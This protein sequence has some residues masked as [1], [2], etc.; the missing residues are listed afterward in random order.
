MTP[1]VYIA[2]GNCNIGNVLSPYDVSIMKVVRLIS[3]RNRRS[4]SSY[5]D[6]PFNELHPGRVL[7]AL[8]P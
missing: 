1:T 7:N 4:V 5:S 6:N 2:V 8:A 3:G